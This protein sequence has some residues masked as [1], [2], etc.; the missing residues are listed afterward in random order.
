MGVN[1]IEGSNFCVSHLIHDTIIQHYVL[2]LFVMCVKKV[3]VLT[4]PQASTKFS[5]LFF[6]DIYGDQS[7]EFVCGSWDIKG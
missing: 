4:S 2:S 6:K 7:G 5:Q 3:K 1:D